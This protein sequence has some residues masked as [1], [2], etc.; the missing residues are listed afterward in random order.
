M[1][2][3]C[4]AAGCSTAVDE[5]SPVTAST[6]SAPFVEPL[7]AILDRPDRPVNIFLVGDG[8]G[9]SLGGWVYLTVQQLAMKTGRSA[10]LGR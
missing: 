6:T 7:S 3:L 5:Y 2:V 10:Q 9:I 8:T 4:L 1:T